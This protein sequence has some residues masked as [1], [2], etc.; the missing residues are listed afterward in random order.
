MSY[1]ISVPTLIKNKYTQITYFR[2]AVDT[3]LSQRE[4]LRWESKLLQYHK[5]FQTWVSI[6]FLNGDP[7]TRKLSSLTKMKPLQYY[8]YSTSCAMQHLIFNTFATKS[9][10]AGLV[11]QLSSFK[12]NPLFC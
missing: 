4:R 12:K 11:L 9:T 10:P 1:L 5:F 8:I 3:E 6:L 2:N 7:T